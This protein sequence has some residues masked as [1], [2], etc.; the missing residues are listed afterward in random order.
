MY[1]LTGD[2]MIGVEQRR[3]EQIADV[4]AAESVQHSAALAA[5]VDKTCET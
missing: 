3:A 5:G 4:T 2:L 1:R